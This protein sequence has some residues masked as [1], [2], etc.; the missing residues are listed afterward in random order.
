MHAITQRS[1]KKYEFAYAGSPAW[2]GLGQ[3][4]TEGASIDD[5][6]RESGLDWEVFE[7]KVMYESAKGHH[8]VPDKRVLFR[9]DNKE[10]LSIVS[11]DYHVVQPGQVL[12]FFRD[13]TE[14]HGFRLSAAGSLFDGKRFW[15]T[16]DVGKSF[17]AV[18]SDRIEG[19]LLLATS[20]DG[21]LATQAKFVSTRVVCNNTLTIAMG[22]SSRNSVRKTHASV[23]DAKEFKLDLGLFNSGWNKFMNDVRKLADIKVSDAFA[24]HFFEKQ[25]FDADLDIEAQ[26][27]GDIKKV[28][29]LMDLYQNGTGAEFSHG[30]AY[31]IMNATTE[32]YTHGITKMRD[33][34][35]Q[36][37]NSH[38]GKDDVIKTNIF[39]EL[40]DQFG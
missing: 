30:T 7:S 29:T 36:F 9:S 2:H 15:A 1:D 6:K 14:Q 16:A 32:L 38:F 21:T 5:W 4:L 10:P 18:D 33:S 3:K 11:K 27:I 25:F 12:E 8:T 22:E 19:Q 40:L 13:I 23:W 34:S 39:N 37:W 31:G 20:V 35:H 26:G 24:R 17:K 28:N